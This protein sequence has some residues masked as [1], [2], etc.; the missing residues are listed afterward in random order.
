MKHLKPL[1]AVT[2]VALA[3]ALPSIAAAQYN[4]RALNHFLDDHQRLKG[5]LSRNPDLIFNRN[6]R[7]D[8]PE[9]QVFM[10]QHPNIYGKIDRSGRWGAF[11]P[12]HN[13]HEADWW[14]EH[15][16]GWMY[17]NHPEWAEQHADWRDDREHHPEW[18]KHEEH[19]EHHEEHA[20]HEA[21][22]EHHAAV[23]S[24]AHHNEMVG[25]TEHKQGHHKDH[26]NKR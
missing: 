24:N 25:T 26:D 8:H 1:L 19:A 18:F 16:P 20:E 12:D 5:E 13:W 14:H 4:D 9:L 6:Y 3:M 22:A 7:R 10:Q 23:E 21:E 17:Q 2:I 15:D 11:G